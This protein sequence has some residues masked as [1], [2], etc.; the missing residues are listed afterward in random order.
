[1]RVLC[2]QLLVVVLFPLLQALLVQLFA[3]CRHTPITKTCSYG[4]A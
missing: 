2:P 4:L 3:I 1:M